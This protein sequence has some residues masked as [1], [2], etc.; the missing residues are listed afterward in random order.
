MQEKS[1]PYLELALKVDI[2]I[3]TSK[4]GL[5]NRK[6]GTYARIAEKG[7]KYARKAEKSGTS[8]RKAKK[9]AK[10]AR[11]A[12]KSGK[13]CSFLPKS[14]KYAKTCQIKTPDS[15]SASSET[16]RYQRA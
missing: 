14:P 8:A 13:I 12:E 15:E 1:G 7:A 11:K 10:Y 6:S 5:K 3:K 9:V 16:P 2:C 4:R